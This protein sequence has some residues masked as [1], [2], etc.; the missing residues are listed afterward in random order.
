MHFIIFKNFGNV[1][2][3]D[4]KSYSIPTPLFIVEVIDF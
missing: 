3:K 2:F 1:D 4:I